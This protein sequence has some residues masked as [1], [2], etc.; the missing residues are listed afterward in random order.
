[1]YTEKSLSVYTNRS[2]TWDHMLDQLTGII[3]PE[4]AQI[5]VEIMMLQTPSRDNI[6]GSNIHL[7]NKPQ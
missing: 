1:M 6:T 3:Y 2:V 5:Y 7:A 4:D